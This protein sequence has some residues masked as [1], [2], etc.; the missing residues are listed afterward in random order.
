MQNQTKK[1]MT[2]IKK[3]NITLLVIIT[4]IRL[5][6]SLIKVIGA[7]YNF[8]LLKHDWIRIDIL[9]SKVL[10]IVHTSFQLPGSRKIP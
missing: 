2:V 6:W 5:F 1:L 9:L 7:A 4:V 8:D 10:H 3:D